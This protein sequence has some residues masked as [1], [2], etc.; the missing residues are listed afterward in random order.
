MMKVVRRVQSRLRRAVLGVIVIA[1]LAP[2]GALAAPP[3]LTGERL[4]GQDPV[5]T[6]TC[7]PSQTSAISF[8]ATGF[9]FGPYETPYP[10]DTGSFTET[11]TAGIGP[12]PDYQG[13]GSFSTGEVTEFSATFSIDTPDAHI[14]G[15]K[16]LDASSAGTGTCQE[17]RGDPDIGNASYLSASVT[18]L[19]YEAQ[20][21]TAEGTFL[22][23]GTSYVEV[24]RF[25]TDTGFPFAGFSETFESSLTEPVRLPGPAPTSAADCKDGGYQAFPALAFKSQG[26]CVAYVRAMRNL[27]Q[28]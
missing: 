6:G 22:D 27:S 20:I 23:R 3:T 25:T 8:A 9:P 5:V 17:V 1:G 7:D 15:T 13:G 19:H 4:D 12:Q 28:P 10:Y 16:T 21:L 26:E 11:G 2:A 14:T 24:D 18:Q